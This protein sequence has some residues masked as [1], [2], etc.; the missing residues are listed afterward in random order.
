MSHVESQFTEPVSAS[1]LP[2]GQ[3]MSLHAV[4]QQRADHERIVVAVRKLR[5]KCFAVTED[6]LRE[7][8]GR[9]MQ[10]L[11]TQDLHRTSGTKPRWPS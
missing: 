8:E 7:I 3:V 9:F 6:D 10:D 4:L 1:S 5:E 11:Y 2:S